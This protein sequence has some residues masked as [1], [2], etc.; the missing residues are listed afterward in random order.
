[1]EKNKE[2]ITKCLYKIKPFDKFKG[3]E[4]PQELL[5][6]YINKFIQK[7]AVRIQ[8]INHSCFI[9]EVTY[10]TLS[11]KTDTNHEWLGSVHGYLMYEV[12][13]KTV[14][15]LFSMA[16]SDDRV[17]ERVEKEEDDDK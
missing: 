14:I 16:K 13:A 17:N 2:I 5:E 3:K 9:G 1:M 15:K 4:I 12:I 11:L 6:K 7:F 8:W 10:W